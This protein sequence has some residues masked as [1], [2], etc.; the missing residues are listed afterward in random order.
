MNFPAVSLRLNPSSGRSSCFYC[1][2][3][4]Y[5]SV[6][7]T[8]SNIY[9]EGFLAVNYLRK[10]A[11]SQMFDWILNTPLQYTD[12]MY[13]GM[14]SLHSFEKYDLACRSLNL[15]NSKTVFPRKFRHSHFC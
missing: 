5:R 12:K 11:P 2:T 13:S 9:D 4:Q 7:R 15:N 6:F 8:Q 1:I 14:A 10:K 3:V